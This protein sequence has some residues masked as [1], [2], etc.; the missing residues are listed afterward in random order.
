MSSSRLA[1]TV[2]LILSGTEV[3]A[4]DASYWT[5]QYG[6][7]ATLL[8]GL[9]VGA[10]TDLSATFYNPGAVALATDPSLM[11]T[12][13]AFQFIDIDLTASGLDFRNSRLR[14]APGMVAADIPGG[15]GAHRLSVSVL[16]RRDFH[17]E[18]RARRTDESS[19]TAAEARFRTSEYWGGATW[20]YAAR[21]GL[22]VGATLY[23]ALR[24]EE[25]A[26][27][28]GVQSADSANALSETAAAEYRYWH[29]RLLAKVGVAW[30]RGPTTLGLTVTTPSL[31]LGGDGEVYVGAS[32]IASDPG[33]PSRI[34]GSAQRDLQPDHR[35]PVSVALGAAHRLGS[36]TAYFTAEWFGSVPEYAVL[37]PSPFVGQTSGDTVAV[38]VNRAEKS[39]V[40]FG[41]GLEAA[42]TEETSL[43]GAFFTN[44]PSTE[45]VSGSLPTAL[46][47]WDIRNV[48]LGIATSFRGIGLTTGLAF[49]FGSDR[50][51]AP[52]SAGRP[53]ATGELTYRSLALL[54]GVEVSL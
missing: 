39:V 19:V 1:V 26:F 49:G 17:F 15:W 18:A 35:S 37:E 43:Y 12:S 24:S 41:L 6:T 50:V 44:A 8:G 25:T 27:D 3:S 4:Q 31:G 54:L 28:A 10:H 30:Q 13:D 38:Q 9:V 2:A 23:G 36:Y 21:D 14:P 5:N 40:N 11:F 22:G 51:E 20:S 42:L 34:E 48:S 47:L 32:S 53:P 16:T 33:V 52:V 45:P 7:R 46:G 29:G